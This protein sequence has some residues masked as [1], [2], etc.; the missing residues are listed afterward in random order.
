M[1][2]IHLVTNKTKI[3]QSSLDS[4][5]ATGAGPWIFSFMLCQ[6]TN[7]LYTVSSYVFPLHQKG[8]PKQSRYC[9]FMHTVIH[10]MCYEYSI[11]LSKTIHCLAYTILKRIL[12]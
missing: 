5:P 12:I 1:T 2:S 10:T 3:L 4:T 9:L 11:Y 7:D 6:K 8:K